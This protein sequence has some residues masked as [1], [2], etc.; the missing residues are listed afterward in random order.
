MNSYPYMVLYWDN[1]Y[2]NQTEHH[3]NYRSAKMSLTKA[4]ELISYS[5]IRRVEVWNG[6]RRLLLAVH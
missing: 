3:I 6:A 1:F 5:W 4:N 2:N